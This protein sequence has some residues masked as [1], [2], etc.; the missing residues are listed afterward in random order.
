MKIFTKTIHEKSI[1]IYQKKSQNLQHTKRLPF[2][3]VLHIVPLHIKAD[4]P[5]RLAHTKIKHTTNLN[6]REMAWSGHPRF[7][8]ILKNKRKHERFSKYSRYATL[9]IIPNLF[10]SSNSTIILLSQENSREDTRFHFPV[11]RIPCDV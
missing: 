11:I 4:I 6:D 8:C 2:F 10:W 3:K 5:N 7:S 9:E 1:Q